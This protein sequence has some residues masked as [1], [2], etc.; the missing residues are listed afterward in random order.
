MVQEK[1]RG[2][3]KMRKAALLA[4][5]VL[6]GGIGLSAG[7][8]IAVDSV[9]TS[10]TGGG[11]ALFDVVRFYA[12][13]LPGGS[14]TAQGAT[15]LNLVAATMTSDQAFKFGFTDKTG[16]GL[17]DWDPIRISPV[18]GGL[19]ASPLTDN[20]NVNTIIA[21]RPYDAPAASQGGSITIPSGLYAIYPT[22]NV[23]DGKAPPQDSQ[24]ND[25]DGTV[26][27]GDFDPRTIYQS[28]LVLGFQ[29]SPGL[30]T[31]RVEMFNSAVDPS[32]LPGN[33]NYDRGAMFAVAVVPKGSVVN[34]AG[35]IAADKGDQ[36]AFNV[37]DGVPEPTSLSLLGLGVMGF[38]AR[39]RRQA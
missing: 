2:A 23:G 1:L 6:V 24:D 5:A 17:P 21:V 20:N 38:L 14:E 32:A 37:T 33:A 7:A 29:T 15:G 4:A 18:S 30:K 27:P 12:K 10:V 34:L 28:P 9:R 26:S 11:D 8:S 19:P 25:G 36:T 22:P 13:I 3:K 31:F 35:S 39:R 16:D